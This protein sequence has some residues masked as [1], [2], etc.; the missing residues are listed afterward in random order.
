MGAALVR[1][2]TLFKDLWVFNLVFQMCSQT[3]SLPFLLRLG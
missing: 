1:V 3:F 2:P